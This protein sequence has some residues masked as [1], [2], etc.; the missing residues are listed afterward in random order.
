MAVISSALS[1]LEAGQLGVCSFGD[2]IRLLHDL[3]QPFSDQSGAAVLRQC[4]FAQERT[5]VAKV[6]GLM[7]PNVGGVH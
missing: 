7:Q 2:D 1:T 5:N 4:S 6:S 3:T